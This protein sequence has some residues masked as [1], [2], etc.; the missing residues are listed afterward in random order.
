MMNWSATAENPGLVPNT[1]G[2]QDV[3]E[4]IDFLAVFSK[5]L[6]DA[7]I[8]INKQTMEGKAAQLSED[9]A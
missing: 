7:V 6:D 1:V 5:E 3:L 8:M 2:N 4:L 9:V